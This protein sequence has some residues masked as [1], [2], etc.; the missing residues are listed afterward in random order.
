M[1]FLLLFLVFAFF[2]SV[3]FGYFSFQVV[4]SSLS[5]S[6]AGFQTCEMLPCM[7]N[8]EKYCMRIKEKYC[9]KIEEKYCMRIAEKYCIRIEEK[10]CIG[11]EEKY[12]K[13]FEEKY[14][15]R[16]RRNTA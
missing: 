10:Y 15:M 4:G 1:F 3:S 11:I 13:R 14:C 5:R 16:L 12:C 6:N 2:S 9:M 7:R 8:R